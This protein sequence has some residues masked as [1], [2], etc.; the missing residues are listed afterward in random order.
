MSAL[1]WVVLTDPISVVRGFRR[2]S[3]KFKKA[4]PSASD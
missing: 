2:L 4:A 3:L 1:H